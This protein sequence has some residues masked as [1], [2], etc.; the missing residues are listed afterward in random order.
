MIIPSICVVKTIKSMI[1]NRLT[2]A[3]EAIL[4]MWIEYDI[5]LKW[6]LYRKWKR[7]WRKKSTHLQ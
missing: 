7:E 4:S 2:R 1:K 3:D 5:C 6:I